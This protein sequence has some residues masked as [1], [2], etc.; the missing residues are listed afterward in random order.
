MEKLREKFFLHRKLRKS[1]K[2]S[3]FNLKLTFNFVIIEN[4]KVKLWIDIKSTSLHVVFFVKSRQEYP[5]FSF[6]RP[7]L[8]KQRV[9]N[10]QCGFF[11]FFLFLVLEHCL[12]R[13]SWKISGSGGSLNSDIWAEIFLQ[14]EQKKSHACS[15][16][17]CVFY[18]RLINFQ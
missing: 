10:H 16:C 2:K 7:S 9:K 6:Q 11:L 3:L 18:Q 4:D 13:F 8:N 12:I 17:K 5:S 14:R 1:K 15:M